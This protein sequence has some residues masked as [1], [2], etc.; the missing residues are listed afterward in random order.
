M[1][2]KRLFLPAILALPLVSLL[3]SP[4]PARA[5]ETKLAALKADA[6]SKPKDAAASF[7]LGR[8][9]RRAGHWGEAKVELARTAALST[10]ADVVKAKYELALVEIDQGVTNPSLPTPPSL[11]PCKAVKVGALG[12][13]LSH[14][15][16][17]QAWLTMARAGMAKDELSLAS[18]SEASLYELKLVEAMVDAENDAHDD[19][20]TKLKALTTSNAT[21]AEGFY[22]LG[23]ELL[24]ASK[25]A[26]AVAPLKKAKDLDS[27]LPEARF[28]LSRALPDGTEARD[29]ARAAVAM[30]STWPEAW[31]RLGELELA[32]NGNDAAKVAFETSIKQNA[33][34]VTAHVGLAFALLRLKNPGEA[35]KAALEAIKL[36]ANNE[37]ARLAH[38][39]ALAALGE[40]DDAVD[41][42]KIAAGLD[43]K[44]ATPLVRAAEVLL[45]AKQP[46]KAEAHA[47]AAVKQFPNDARAW[48][49]KGDAA[50]ANGDKKGAK[51]AYKRA[52]SCT[53]GSIDKVAVQKKIDAIK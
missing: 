4:P 49:V 24:A 32:T 3:C 10:G 50:L 30:R 21:R 47:D 15:C 44:D 23:R 14:V 28:A 36:A 52:L 11:V 9:L 37:S 12:D 38:A 19:A 8:A 16:A 25:R 6:K 39:E 13:A 34:L 5:Q 26:E 17:A 7:A 40:T 53:E 48:Q 22:W 33:K 27:D 35:K 29:E 45:A 41:V 18:K 43:A 31:L 51:E 20:I 1:R 42:F 2:T 46:V